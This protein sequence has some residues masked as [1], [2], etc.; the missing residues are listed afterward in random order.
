LHSGIE[1]IL[2]RR[3][4]SPGGELLGRIRSV[5]D[6]AMLSDIQLL[7]ATADDLVSFMDHLNSALERAD[8]TP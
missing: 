6:V 4:R 7:A 2:E 8:A 3:F 5:R 1:A